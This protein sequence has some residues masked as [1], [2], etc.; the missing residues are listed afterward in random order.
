MRKAVICKYELAPH[1]S[2]VH[3][4]VK[5]VDAPNEKNVLEFLYEKIG[6]KTV[7]VAYLPNNILA[8]VNDEGMIEGGNVVCDYGN[9]AILA[10][11]IVFSASETGHDGKTNWL[12]S[13]EAVNYAIDIAEKSELKGV[14]RG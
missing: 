11:T 12:D 6:C 3:R 14:T 4:D 7:D 10:G 8:W 9:G 1:G 2:V 5:V 13:V